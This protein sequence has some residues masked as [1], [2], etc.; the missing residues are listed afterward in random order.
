VLR[1]AGAGTLGAVLVKSPPRRRPNPLRR[2]L[3]YD[4]GLGLLVGGADEAGRGALAGPLVAAAVLLAPRELTAAQR[5]ALRALD[6]SKRLTRACRERLAPAVLDAALA[7]AVIVRGVPDVD[8]RGV[9]HANLRAL[10]AALTSLDAP[11]GAVLVA[12]G[13]R[14][15]LAR[16]HTAIIDGDQ[17]SAAI[18]AASI[19]AKVTR[20]RLMRE[21]AERYPVY[22]FEHNVGYATPEHLH[23]LR[24]SGPSPEHRRSFACCAL[25]ATLF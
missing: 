15:P 9:H 19:I 6:D 1:A 14:L 21:T 20:D 18:A 25:A 24:L 2:L 17:T 13:F 16:P 3:R 12:D 5:R 4:L 11:A 23:A 22:G 10:A 7:V 8:S